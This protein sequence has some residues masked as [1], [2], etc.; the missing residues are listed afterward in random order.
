MPETMECQL[1][2]NVSVLHIHILQKH[3]K[4]TQLLRSWQFRELV[5]SYARVLV[6]TARYGDNLFIFWKYMQPL[7]IS[8]VLSTIVCIII[9]K[10]YQFRWICLNK[11]W[12]G[13]NGDKNC[14]NDSLCDFVSF[15][16][17]IFISNSGS[18]I[19]WTEIFIQFGAIVAEH[20]AAQTNG[21]FSNTNKIRNS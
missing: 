18:V 21:A 15:I 8:M 3:A 5:R 1:L 6:C 19:G 12:R 20:V 9:T 2:I 11:Y 14:W 4:H 16:F 13:K 17:G 7:S 10:C